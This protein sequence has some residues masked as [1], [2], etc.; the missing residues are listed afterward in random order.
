MSLPNTKFGVCLPLAL[1]FGILFFLVVASGALPSAVVHADPLQSCTT[2]AAP[3]TI[4]PNLELLSITGPLSTGAF[5]CTEG[6]GGSSTLNTSATDP[7]QGF[8]D[9]PALCA[10]VSSTA[11]ETI[12]VVALNGYEIE[13]F[14]GSI[15]CGVS[16][17]D[18]LSFTAG[19]VVLTCPGTTGTVSSDATFAPV[20]SL[21][22]TITASNVFTTGGSSS[23]SAG[24]FNFSL[25]ATPEPSSLLLLSSGLVGL[26]FL[27]RKVLQN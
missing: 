8:I 5:P 10:P 16:G 24:G 14:S 4:G 2:S 3:C 7:G 20:T 26:G 17:G 9:S 15:T 13:D 12:S 21:T 25:V 27:K 22:E 6:A 18:S 1:A 23:E 11:S 19:S